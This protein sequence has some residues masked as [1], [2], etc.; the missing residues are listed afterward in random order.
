[1]FKDINF[2]IG[3]ENSTQRFFVGNIFYNFYLTKDKQKA[4]LLK[5]YIQKESFQNIFKNDYLTFV[6]TFRKL[7][8]IN[9]YTYLESL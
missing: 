4:R 8:Y 1:M 5:N 9:L 2:T 3:F 6:K 7:S